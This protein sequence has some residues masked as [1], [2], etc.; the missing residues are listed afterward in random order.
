MAS[1]EED[2]KFTQVIHYTT[3][4]IC[5]KIEKETEIIFSKESIAMIADLASRQSV[6]FAH[7]LELFAKHAKRKRITADDLFLLTRKTPSLC[8]HLAELKPDS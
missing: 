1:I 6:L 7:D 4:K 3:G 5:K 8:R 2:E